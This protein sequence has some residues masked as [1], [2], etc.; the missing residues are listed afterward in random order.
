MLK[1]FCLTLREGSQK[2]RGIIL[3]ENRLRRYVKAHCGSPVSM[4]SMKRLP[5][6]E[7]SDRFRCVIPCHY[8]LLSHRCHTTISRVRMAFKKK[9]LGN[10][11]WLCSQH[12]SRASE[13]ARPVRLTPIW[14][15]AYSSS[16]DSR[17]WTRTHTTGVCCNSCLLQGRGFVLSIQQCCQT[18]LYP[19]VGLSC[20]LWSNWVSKARS[21]SAV[22]W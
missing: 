4:K 10:S 21:K 9:I 2:M 14:L 20:P 19:Y 1:R 17:R 13:H 18:S 6:Q 16:I 15:S 3:S 5:H 22:L 8:S 12:S 7:Q 11:D